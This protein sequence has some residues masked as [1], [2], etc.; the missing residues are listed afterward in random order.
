MSVVYYPG[1]SQVQVQENLRV[2]TIASITNANPMVVTTVND[3]GYVAGITVTFLI[4]TQFGMVQLNNQVAQVISVTDDTLTINLDST[5]FSVFAY[6]SPL[7][8]AYTPPSIIP[9]SSG[10]YLPPL[11]LPFGNQ[12]SFEGVIFN[13]GIPTNPINGIPS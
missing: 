13:N 10:P 3:H 6:P 12:D 7:P 1:Y 9:T 4:P 11:P 5:H 8:E 2:Q